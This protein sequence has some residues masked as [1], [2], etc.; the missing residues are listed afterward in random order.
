MAIVYCCCTV[1]PDEK[2]RK[3]WPTGSPVSS[4]WNSE[5][6][7]PTRS[8]SRSKHNFESKSK[9]F[10]YGEIPSKNWNRL[11][12][13]LLRDLFSIQAIF[14]FL[15]GYQPFFYYFWITFYLTPEGSMAF[16]TPFF[17]FVLKWLLLRRHVMS[18]LQIFASKTKTMGCSL[19]EFHWN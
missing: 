7:C 2:C 19:K 5:Y 11:T 3:S 4:V 17:L 13:M 15:T 1:R 10:G 6:I 16:W 18:F 14:A 12:N 8:I 9:I